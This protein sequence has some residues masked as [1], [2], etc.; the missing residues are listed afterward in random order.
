MFYVEYM[1]LLVLVSLISL[2]YTHK[3]T[4]KKS[5]KIRYVNQ[6]KCFKSFYDLGLSVR[7]KDYFYRI[8][9]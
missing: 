2:F 5:W 3:S 8:A 6:S 7:H 4:I 1:S 9:K